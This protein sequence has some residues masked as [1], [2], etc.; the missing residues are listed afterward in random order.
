S[1]AANGNSNL[2]PNTEGPGGSNASIFQTENMVQISSAGQRISDNNFLLDG[3]SAN[4]LTW[5]GAAVVTPNEASI[6]EINVVTNGYSAQYGRNSG[7]TVEVVSKTGTN[8][9]HGSG[10]FK[11]DDPGLNAYNKY[12]GLNNLPARVLDKSRQF[13]GSLGGPILKNK[14]FFFGS[15]EGLRDNKSDVATQ[16]VL[17]PQFVQQVISLRPG[18]VSAKVLQSAGYAPRIINVLPQSCNVGFSKTAC[19]VVSGGLDLGSITGQPNFF[20]ATAPYGNPAAYVNDFNSSTGG[21]FDGVPDVEFV[22]VA[23]PS[24]VKGNQFNYRMDFDPTDRDTIAGSTYVTLFNNT[25]AD[26]STGSE[27]MADINLKP[28]NSVT[29]LLWNHTFSPTILNQARANFTRYAYNQVQSNAAADFGIPRIEIQGFPFGRIEIGPAWSPNTPGIEAENTIAFDDSLNQVVGNKTL[30]YGFDIIKEQ[31]N[32]NL[33]GGARPDIV[34]QYPWDFANAAPIFEEIE[35][36]PVT[37]LPTTGQRYFRTSDYALFFENDWKLRP[38]FTLNLGLRWEYFTPLSETRGRLSNFVFG[39]NG[40]VTKVEATSQLYNTDKNNFGPRFGFAWSPGFFHNKLVWRGGFGI[41]YN[42]LPE[43]VFDN[44]RQDPPFT[45][46]ISTCCGTS[47]SPNNKGQLLYALGANKSPS[48]FPPNPNWATGIDPAT[49]SLVGIPVQI[50]GAFQNTPNPYVEEWSFGEEYALTDTWRWS[51]NYEGSAGHKVD[52]LLNLNYLYRQPTA[53]PFSGGVFSL[54]P[55]V[56]TA[57][58]ALSTSMSHRFSSGLLATVNYRY[59]KSIDESS[60]E[61]PCFCTNE[62]YP[63]SL[64]SERGPSDYDVT[65]YLTMAAVYELPFFKG[66][67][68][69]LGEVLGGWELDPI[70]TY[71]S[72]FPWT[73]VSGQSVQTPG[74]PTL[75]PTRP[76]AYYG[77]AIDDTTNQA[78]TRPDGDFPGGPS[79]Y[80]DFSKSGPPGVGRNSFRGP[81][82]IDT[83]LSFG[84]NVRLPAAFHLGEQANLEL[85]G[86]FFNFFNTENLA[87]FGFGSSS[88][89]VDNPTFFG[90]AT[91]GLAGRVAELQGTISF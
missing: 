30:K 60:W 54:I 52:R 10:F 79:R 43:Q 46:A 24:N 78:F 38:N 48:S 63:Q 14:L 28:T 84:K 65:H 37:G 11:Y 16:Y 31:S 15:Y 83:D 20:S 18:S 17:T 39:S 29:T 41:F 82:Y 89:H 77:G 59:G 73:P 12:N 80:F 9:L 2:L 49:G 81:H 4:S 34:F 25:G 64:K 5:G 13:G 69:L 1:R 86:N 62:T 74:G 19:Q 40:Q 27:P 72:G 35:A 21:G 85:R 47:G 91:A 32:N 36:D 42:R 23:V 56:N 67:H 6:Q 70:F 22:Q 75:S 51:A 58:D 55:D 90:R 26:S 50:Y 33:L 87:P 76:I 66:A 61:G 3:V 53:D 68:S 8:Q 45:S 71:H 7:A 44:I 57:Y 88:T